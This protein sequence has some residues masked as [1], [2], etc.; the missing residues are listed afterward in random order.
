MQGVKQSVCPSVA[1]VGTKIAKFQ[2]LGICAYCNYNESI[3]IFVKL[4][5]VRFK[6]LNMAH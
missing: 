1:V 2:V 4:V 6:L 3:D 5:S